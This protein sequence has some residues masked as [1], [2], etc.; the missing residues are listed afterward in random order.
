M[1]E[2]HRDLSDRPLGPQ[3]WQ[4]VLNKHWPQLE[5]SKRLKDVPTDQQIDVIARVVF[6]VDGEQHLAGRAVRWT[7][8]HVCVAIDDPRLQVAY[9]WLAPADV[10]RSRDGDPAGG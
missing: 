10:T 1:N 2:A 9:V 8:Q 6:A 4:R 5:V 3:V 7:R